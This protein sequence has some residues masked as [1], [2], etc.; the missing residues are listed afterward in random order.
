M[1]YSKVEDFLKDDKFIEFVLGNSGAD[2][3]WGNLLSQ[4]PKIEYIFEEAKDIVNGNRNI[5]SSLFSEDE[6]ASLRS[7]IFSDLGIDR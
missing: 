3:Y 1:V 7:D 4:N 2:S 6:L 5:V